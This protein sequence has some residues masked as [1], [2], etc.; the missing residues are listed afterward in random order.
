MPGTNVPSKQAII[1]AKIADG[2]MP[3]KNLYLFSIENFNFFTQHLLTSI[4][5]IGSKL[6]KLGVNFS[7]NLSK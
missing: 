4:N 3:L 6:I 5:L 1:S 2:N 7:E